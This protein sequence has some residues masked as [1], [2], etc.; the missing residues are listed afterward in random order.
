MRFLRRSLTVLPTLFLATALGACAADGG[1]VDEGDP[2]LTPEDLSPISTQSIEEGHV[3]EPDPDADV[4]SPLEGREAEGTLSG[5]WVYDHVQAFANSACKYVGACSNGTYNGHS[6][7]ASRATDLMMSPYGTITSA[8]NAKGD[9]LVQFATNNR[10]KF[11]IMY[12]I[13]HQRINSFDG[14]G[15]RAM[16]NRG[17]IT[18]NH[19][20]HVHVSFYTTA[21]MG[22]AINTSGS[23][24]S[25]PT[26][27]CN[28]YTLGREV[29]VGTCV[30]SKVDYLWYQ[31]GKSGSWLS[32]PKVRTGGAGP[33][34]T[35]TK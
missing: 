17:S 23:G 33:I 29:N 21:N 12:V 20:D 25:T 8:G 35:C 18:Q 34:G 10:K 11:G 9:R 13:W 26:T 15:W 24:G 6:P 19:F 16:E 32:A 31:C 1:A 27:T 28:S 5:L 14:R 4:A 3:D 2:T 7:T 30:Q 22:I